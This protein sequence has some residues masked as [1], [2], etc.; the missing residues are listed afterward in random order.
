MALSV[1]ETKE[2]QDK[3]YKDPPPVMAVVA[4]SV[5]WIILMIVLDVYFTIVIR[6]HRDAFKDFDII[7][8]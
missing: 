1:K 2:D 7:Y 6:A 3:F 5:I 4:I 8:H